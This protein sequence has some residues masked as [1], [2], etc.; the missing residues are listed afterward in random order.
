MDFDVH[1]GEL[2]HLLNVRA[3]VADD[4][5]D[6]SWVNGELDA[7]S[8]ALRVA[9]R[10]LDGATHSLDSFLNLFEVARDVDE[11]LPGAFALRGRRA[12]LVGI[13][14]FTVVAVA[15]VTIVTVH[16]N[17]SIGTTNAIPDLDAGTG[18]GADFGDGGAVFTNDTSRVLARDDEMEFQRVRSRWNRRAWAT[19]DTAW[20][21]I[22]R[23]MT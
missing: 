20:M 22:M 23:V 8:A 18:I 10:L 21:I 5:T 19:R 14:I 3:L 12:G 15:V 7:H 9:R 2:T 1:A 17:G 13:A 6:L 16:G 4:R 11:T